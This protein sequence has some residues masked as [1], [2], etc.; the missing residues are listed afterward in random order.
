[1]EGR[2]VTIRETVNATKERYGADALPGLLEGAT[3]IVVAKGKK[4]LEFKPGKDEH[5]D[6]AKVVLGPSGNLRAPSIRMG[7]TWLVGFNEEAYTA[8]FD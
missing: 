1:M 5:E 4:V 8:K 2:D 6:I 7:K 3:R